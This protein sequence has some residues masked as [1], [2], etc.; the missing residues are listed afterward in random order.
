[1]LEDCDNMF[2]RRL[3]DSEAGTPIES[4]FIE[5]ETLPLRFI[6]QGRQ[7]MYYHTLLNKSESELVKRVYIAQREFPSKNDWLSQTKKTL[8]S[9]EFYISEDEIKKY[10]KYKFKKLVDSKVKQ[11]AAEYLTELQ[12]KL[13]KLK[14]LLQ[15]NKMQEYL[16]SDN[17]TT[18]QKKMLFKMRI[19]MCPNKTNFKSM[20]QP[21][22]SC[23]LCEET[24]STE[25]EHHL[26]CCPFLM[27]IPELG[28]EMKNIKYEDIFKDIK[29]QKRAVD[30]WITIFNIYNTEKDKRKNEK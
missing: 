17:L 24:S 2:M 23:S 9:C 11:K 13:S 28:E 22:L 20:Y 14:Y 6:L 1:M 29:K 15:T 8:L 18:E 19:R 16:G 10:S 27:K 3:F 7:L 4:F 12:M 25:S 26:L 5:T 30:V 21:D